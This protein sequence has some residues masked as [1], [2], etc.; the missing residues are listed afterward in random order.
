MQSGFFFPFAY[1][2]VGV[3]TCNI[4]EIHLHHRN[5]RS[6][7]PCVSASAARRYRGNDRRRTCRAD[8][9]GDWCHQGLRA[10]CDVPVPYDCTTSAH[11]KRSSKSCNVF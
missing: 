2:A 8:V 5:D 10:L 1:G 9:L 3:N 11:E 4:P 6:S 7:G